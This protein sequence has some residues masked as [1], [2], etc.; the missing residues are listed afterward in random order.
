MGIQWCF[1]T[2]HTASTLVGELEWPITSPDPGPSFTNEDSKVWQDQMWNPFASRTTL[3]TVLPVGSRSLQRGCWFVL[4]KTQASRP[5]RPQRCDHLCL[6]SL[7]TQAVSIP[8]GEVIL[9]NDQ[10]QQADKHFQMKICLCWEIK[11]GLSLGKL[12]LPYV[13]RIGWKHNFYVFKY[14]LITSQF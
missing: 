11:W 8:G 10:H 12:I 3:P 6:R 2:V 1:K 7:A 13:E 14:K 5:L 4:V 9:L